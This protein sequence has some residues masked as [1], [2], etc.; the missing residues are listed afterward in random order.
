VGDRNLG[1]AFAIVLALRLFAFTS[2][3]VLSYACGLV[4]FPF[5]WFLLATALGAVPKVFAF[6]YAGASIGA[7]ARLVG[8]LD[9]CQGQEPDTPHRRGVLE[10]DDVGLAVPV[11][12]TQHWSLRGVDGEPGG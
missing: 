9:D 3:D 7:R 4:R 2:F 5:R 6:T 8:M 10:G 1:G 12:V 11:E